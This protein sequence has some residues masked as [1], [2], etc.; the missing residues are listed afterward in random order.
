[1]NNFSEEWEAWKIAMVVIFLLLVTV[2]MI[3]I[4]FGDFLHLENIRP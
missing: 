3:G 4:V 2:I 1:M